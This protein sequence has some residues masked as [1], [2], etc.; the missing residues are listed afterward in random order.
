MG[1]ESTTHAAPA[2]AGEDVLASEPQILAD[3]PLGGDVDEYGQ[4]D[5]A[6]GFARIAGF[7]TEVEATEV[8]RHLVEAGIGATVAGDVER[9][10]IDP[11]GIYG[12][13]VLYEDRRR[14]A[15]H[16]GI[17]EREDRP[18]ASPEQ[19]IVVDR[20]PIPWKSVLPIFGLAMVLV[21]LAAGLLTY[22][23]MS[24]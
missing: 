7:P 10:G 12:V 15:E 17:V 22:F 6:V 23:V 16:L 9:A 2:P 19:P 18:E 20:G 8:A 13:H 21:P 4:Q 5:G 14:A 11:N 3:A 24:R 1:D